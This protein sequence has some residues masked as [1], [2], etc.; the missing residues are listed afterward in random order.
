MQNIEQKIICE[1]ANRTI[2]EAVDIFQKADSNLPY[3]K[4]KKLVTLCDKSCCITP[5][6]TLFKMVKEKN[7]D[8]HKISFLIDER[9]KWLKAQ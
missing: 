3:K 2:K 5:L 4:V 1:C 7:I 9:N 6:I 8:Y